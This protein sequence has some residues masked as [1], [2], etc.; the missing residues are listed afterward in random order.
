MNATSYLLMFPIPDIP[1]YP[2]LQLLG[3]MVVSI[4]A[5]TAEAAT[6]ASDRSVAPYRG[7]LARVWRYVGGSP[8]RF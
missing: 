5:A 1:N 7:L 6:P 2:K 3:S 4:I 8:R